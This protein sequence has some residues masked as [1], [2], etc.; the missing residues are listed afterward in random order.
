M[1][2]RTSQGDHM[3]EHCI[4]FKNYILNTDRELIS[5]ELK[6]NPD[7]FIDYFAFTTAIGVS[8]RWSEHFLIKKFSPPQWCLIEDGKDINSVDF[9]KLMLGLMRQVE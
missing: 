7:I 4:G 8:E 2:Q 6:E 9:N 1:S 5:R 3:Y